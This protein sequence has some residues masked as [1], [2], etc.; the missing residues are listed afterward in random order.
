VGVVV[1]FKARACRFRLF[2]TLA[3][4]ARFVVGVDQSLWKHFGVSPFATKGFSFSNRG[5]FVNLFEGICLRLPD[6][7]LRQFFVN[8]INKTFILVVDVA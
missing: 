3:R 7:T 6:Y 5:H 8:S 1:V 4:Q 2:A